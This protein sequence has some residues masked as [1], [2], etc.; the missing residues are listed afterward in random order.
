MRNSAQVALWAVYQL[1]VQGQPGPKVVCFQHEWDAVEAA[2]PGI[3][4]L[5]KGGIVSLQFF[6]RGC[7]LALLHHLLPSRLP[8]RPTFPVRRK[9]PAR[10]WFSHWP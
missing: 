9:M 2:S 7:E 8:L 6:N 3:H 1:T 10:S 5:I 4:R